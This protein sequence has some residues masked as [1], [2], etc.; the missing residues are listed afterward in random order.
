MGYAAVTIAF[1]LA[2]IQLLAP[3]VSLVQRLLAI[4]AGSITTGAP[5]HVEA[6]SHDALAT[7]L[8]CY[9]ASAPTSKEIAR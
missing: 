2:V 8:G 1:A 9:S 3:R 4:K 6:M 7:T 5:L